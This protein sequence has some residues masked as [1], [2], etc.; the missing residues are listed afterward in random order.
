M[1]IITVIDDSLTISEDQSEGNYTTET[2]YIGEII[3]SKRSPTSSEDSLIFQEE[4]MNGVIYIPIT[5]EFINLYRI[6][7]KELNIDENSYTY[8]FYKTN[9][10][11]MD[12]ESNTHHISNED[13]LF[14]IAK[15]NDFPIP[16]Y[17]NITIDFVINCSHF[18]LTNI[19]EVIKKHSCEKQDLDTSNYEVID[20]VLRLCISYYEI[21][22]NRNNQLYSMIDLLSKLESIRI[23]YNNTDL[24]GI[25]SKII[26]EYYTLKRLNFNDLLL[27]S[28]YDIVIIECARAYLNNYE[29]F[30]IV[31][32]YHRKVITGKA[33]L[34][35]DEKLKQLD[36]ILI[37][38]AYG[39]TLDMYSNIDK[40]YDPVGNYIYKGIEKLI[41]TPVKYKLIY[42][43][44][45]SDDFMK[46]K[47]NGEFNYDLNL[48]NPNDVTIIN[49]YVMYHCNR[50]FSIKNHIIKDAIMGDE[51]TKLIYEAKRSYERLEELYD[52]FISI[53]SSNQEIDTSYIKFNFMYYLA[54]S[55]ALYNNYNLFIDAF[56]YCEQSMINSLCKV[57]FLRSE[58]YNIQKHCLKNDVGIDMLLFNI[59]YTGSTSL[60][61][62]LS[63]YILD[64][65]KHGWFNS[66]DQVIEY[67]NNNEDTSIYHGRG[68][69]AEISKIVTQINANLN[70]DKIEY[71]NKKEFYM[72]QLRRFHVNIENALYYLI[73]KS[74]SLTEQ[75]NTL[76][77]VK[78]NI[79]IIEKIFEKNVF[80]KIDGFNYINLLKPMLIA[81]YNK[82]THIFGKI[83]IYIFTYD[84]ILPK[85][86]PNFI[87]SNYAVQS[88]CR[89]FKLVSNK[90]DIDEI[91]DE[92][93]SQEIHEAIN[94]NSIIK[95]SHDYDSKHYR[96]R[97]KKIIKK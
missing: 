65:Y 63:N 86:D 16:I 13:I 74:I 33:T 94:R 62:A 57:A 81:V 80:G 44:I 85:I 1:S 70:L 25:K 11:Y 83:A 58:S 22:Y 84:K 2:S 93:S 49:N 88:M 26:V 61:S 3:S 8:S 46:V 73:Q 4:M 20:L 39:F 43:K 28:K 77:I 40:E 14:K 90:Q 79:N 76:D 38:P 95:I 72:K 87:A 56:K 92:Q 53:R 64:I 7:N 9:D 27:N 6:V 52:R 15:M 67:R 21:L 75:K 48:L 10:N 36:I 82:A 18:A 5:N 34:L 54:C 89:H 69:K 41:F 91:Y 35:P 59:S 17:D 30:R 55:F 71:N 60:M 97:V 32:K 66:I 42:N 68:I 29:D 51:I 12:D 19:K 37:N 31:D 24:L 96:L 23:N 47:D 50:M 45:L 78:I